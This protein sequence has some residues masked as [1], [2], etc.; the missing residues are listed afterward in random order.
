MYAR[1]M[2]TTI[3]KANAPRGRGDAR[4]RRTRGRLPARLGDAGE[5]ARERHLAE[6]AAVQA[7]LPVVPARRARGL[8]ATANAHGGAVPWHLRE[9]EHRVAL[10]FPGRVRVDDLRLESGALLF[11]P[12]RERDLLL[13]LRNRGRLGHVSEPS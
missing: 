10:L 9:R 2:S 3:R 12:L 6:R 4:S 13:F 5:Q 1:V 11:V 8:A 7:E